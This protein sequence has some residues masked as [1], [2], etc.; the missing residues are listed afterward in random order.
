MSFLRYICESFRINKTESLRQYWRQFKM[1]YDRING[2]KV[3][4]NDAR[5]VVK[6]Q[7]TLLSRV[8]IVEGTNVTLVYCRLGK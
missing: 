4:S 8:K 3:D 6:V 7:G 1:L 5:E 2:S